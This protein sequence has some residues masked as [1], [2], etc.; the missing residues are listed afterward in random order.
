MDR[1]THHHRT[2]PADIEGKPGI[3]GMNRDPKVKTQG[4]NW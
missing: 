1:K 3:A 4:E 2:A